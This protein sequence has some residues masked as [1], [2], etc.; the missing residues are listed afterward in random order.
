MPAAIGALVIM[1][2]LVSAGFYMARQELR[3]GVA[4]NFANMALN[5]A[6]GG[7]NEVMANWNGYQLG[8]IPMWGDTTIVDTTDVGIWTVNITNTNN[9]IYY[10]DATGEITQ[11]EAWGGATR[12]IGI[13]TRLIY[14][15]IHP[16]GALTT[17]GAVNVKGTAE[18]IGTDE[19]PAGWSSYCGPTDDMAGVVTDDISLVTTTGSGTIDGDP[20]AEEDATIVD[21]TFTEFGDLDWAELTALAQLEGKDITGLGNTISSANPVLD[22]SGLCDEAVLT[23]WGDIDPTQPCGSYFPLMYHGGD[24]RIQS[25]GMGQGILLVEGDLDL[26]GGF[27]FHGIIIVQGTFQTQ[28]GGERVVGAVMAGNDLTLDQDFTGGS[29]IQYSS[30]G[31]Q[32]AILNNASLSRARPLA[33]RSWIDLSALLN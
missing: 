21:E 4:S 10:L 14:A 31:V 9:V 33:N 11:G 23:N 25:G 8:N 20:P 32:R 22:G 3:I 12:N 29:T 16:P 19:V 1:A 15:D 26:R 18:I 24:I 7:S 13:V 17:R 28:G 2:A 6:Q 27:V 5:V 30:C